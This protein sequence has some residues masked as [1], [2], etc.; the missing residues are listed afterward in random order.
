M[1][2]REPSHRDD[3][4]IKPSSWVRFVSHKYPELIGC[5]VWLSYRCDGLWALQ[6]G[7]L[8]GFIFHNENDFISV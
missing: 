8:H 5:K 4:E 2:Y 7:S 3:Y 1:I 6:Y